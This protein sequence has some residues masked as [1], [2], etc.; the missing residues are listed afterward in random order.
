M[1]DMAIVSRPTT[2]EYRDNWPFD[3]KP[4]KPEFESV[5]A[6]SGVTAISGGYSSGGKI[7]KP[8]VEAICVYLRAKLPVGH[9][10]NCET[11]AWT[12]EAHHEIEIYDGD[13]Y[14]KTTCEEVAAALEKEFLK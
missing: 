10:K 11:C 12:A 9:E 6:M 3:A 8:T 1:I 13:S 7:D 2:K 5:I 14:R 4:E